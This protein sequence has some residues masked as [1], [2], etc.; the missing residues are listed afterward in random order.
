MEEDRGAFKMVTGNPTGNI[1]L[2]RPRRR[3]K[4]NIRIDLKEI[5]ANTRNCVDTAE[6]KDNCRAL[7][8]K[9]SNLWV[10]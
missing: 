2:G 4:E 6:H 1:L 9:A 10:P 5:D 3:W 8:N 7:L